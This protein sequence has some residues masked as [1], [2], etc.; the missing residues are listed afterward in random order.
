M[1]SGS[2]N[3]KWEEGA[4]APVGRYVHTAVWLNGLVYVGGGLETGQGDSYG[5]YCYDPVNDSWN[6]SPINSSYC[7]FVMTTLNNNLL[8]A[9]GRDKNKKKTNKIFTMDGG[10]LKNY[11]KMIT[12]R[13][14]ATGAGH[15]GILIIVGGW[16]DNDK[17]LSSTELFDSNNGKWYTCS[18]LPKPHSWLKSV[19]ANNIL[20]VFGGC[21]EDEDGH[22]KAS[23]EVFTATL[24]TLSSHQ[25]KWK[26]YQDTPWCRPTPVGVHGIH[27]LIVGGVE[28]IENEYASIS[29][30]QKLDKVTHY[31]E[32]I[33]NIPSARY[34]SGACAADNRIVVIG[35]WNKGEYTNTIWI[36]SCEPQ[37]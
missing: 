36:G 23:S 21:N 37:H 32:A 4:P 34:G 3:I 10:Q 19:I 2:V 25:L 20:Y 7:H 13:S 8:I 16:D 14:S 22:G 17:R 26:R 35:G 12:A 29:D 11:A 27:L 28:I 31:W 9:G 18:D 33:G 30:V 15:R 6:S 1:F 24:D 5:I